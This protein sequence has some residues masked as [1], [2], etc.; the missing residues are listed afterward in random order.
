MKKKLLP[1]LLTS[2]FI[3][4][5]SKTTSFYDKY[6]NPVLGE[7][8]NYRTYYEIFPRS[9]ADSNGDYYGDLNGIRNK[10][11]YIENLG[12]NGI[13]LTPINATPS[14]H[15]YDITDYKKINPLFG[16]IDDY[17]NLIKDCHSRDI[18]II[19]DLVLN[20]TSTEH[21]WFK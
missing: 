16:T 7:S 19:L 18:K 17:K 8:D 10:L 9:F 20:H 21:E 12:F 6:K 15:G 4:G 3:T 5:C 1:L 14:Y 11:D 13:W 2:I